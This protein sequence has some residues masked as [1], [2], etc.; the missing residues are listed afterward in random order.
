MASFPGKG[1]LRSPPYSRT[2]TS[3]AAD[4]NLTTEVEQARNA[5]SGLFVEAGAGD[6][7]AW[8][9]CAGEANTKTFTAAWAGVLPFAATLIDSTTDVISVT[10]FWHPSTAR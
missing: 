4:I 2:Y 6:V 1:D 8:E 3:F 7:L 10:V 5:C 9:D